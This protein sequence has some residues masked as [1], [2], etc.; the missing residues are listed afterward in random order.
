MRP[1]AT[2][3]TALYTVPTG[4]RARV[5]VH[6]TNTDTTTQDECSLWLV[7]SG[8]VLGTDNQIVTEL[9]LAGK[10]DQDAVSSNNPL[11]LNEGEAI[12]GESLSN[13]T[14]NY[15]CNGYED[16]LPT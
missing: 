7:K 10:A 4:R 15:F 12:W 2:T 13:G 1:A 16:D 3:Q 6:V 11:Y 8:D 5:T 9:A 14:L